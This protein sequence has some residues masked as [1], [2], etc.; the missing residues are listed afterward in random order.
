[1]YKQ[2]KRRS[3]Y[4]S[5]DILENEDYEIILLENYPCNSKEE[6]LAREKYWIGQMLCVNKYNPIGRDKAKIKAKNKRFYEQHKQYFQERNKKYREE[7]AEKM[8]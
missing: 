3:R 4:A 8:K 2:G 7:N 6:L 1:L 5:F